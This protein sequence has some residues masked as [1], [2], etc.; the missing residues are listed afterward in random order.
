MIYKTDGSF[1]AIYGYA[2]HDMFRF[3]PRKNILQSVSVND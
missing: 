1:T 2:A 3:I